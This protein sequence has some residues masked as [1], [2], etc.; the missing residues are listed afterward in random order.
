[1]PKEKRLGI[2][3]IGS[4]GVRALV[5][6]TEN[7]KKYNTLYSERFPIRLGA[8]VFTE[9][10]IS[11]KKRDDLAT[12]LTQFK[13]LIEDFQVS[14]YFIGATS[15]LR[16][17]QNS[18]E[19]IEDI[20]KKTEMKINL[21]DGELE[22]RLIQ[23]A[24]TNELNLKEYNSLILDIGGGSCEFILGN[25][26]LFQDYASL[27]I[28]AVRLIKGI[29]K[30]KPYLTREFLE[31]II[32]S[33][34]KEVDHFKRHLK[35]DPVFVATGGNSRFLNKLSRIIFNHETKSHST[36]REIELLVNIL[37]GFSHKDRI[38][39]LD[40]RS[41]RADVI[42]PASLLILRTMKHFNFKKALTPKIGLRHGLLL[43]LAEQIQS[44]H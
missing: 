18:Q 23:L 14:H 31:Q 43:H 11:I 8:D 12:A 29:N 17:A 25:K 36:M 9:D 27:K 19:I 33:Y 40:V 28:G 30:E 44:S 7:Y 6:S 22:A 39:K 20:F 5:A 15:A 21:I 37:F 10:E 32:H 34:I 26:G 13:T 24:V 41:D 16:E 3:D 2:V 35:K 42:L 1:M 4:N 38:N